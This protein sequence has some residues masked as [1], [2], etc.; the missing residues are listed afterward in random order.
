MFAVLFV[1]GLGAGMGV[2]QTAAFASDGPSITL[3]G[4]DLTPSALLHVTR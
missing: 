2:P 3:S 4:G 1:V